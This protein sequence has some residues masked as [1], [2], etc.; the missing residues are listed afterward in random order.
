[1][2]SLGYGAGPVAHT[3]AEF[4]YSVLCQAQPR[5]TSPRSPPEL[6]LI[7]P[8]S[9]PGARPELVRSSP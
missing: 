4:A 8:L 6:A 5:A 9:L 1:M 3:D 2:T 7:S